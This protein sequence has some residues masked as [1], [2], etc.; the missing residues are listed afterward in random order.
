MESL[1]P[2]AP[3]SAHRA[4]VP[5][6]ELEIADLVAFGRRRDR[7]DRRPNGDRPVK[8]GRAPGHNSFQP[9][10]VHEVRSRMRRPKASGR[11]HLESCIK[12][13]DLVVVFQ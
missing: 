7:G 2:S 12:E 8:L 6:G 9:R 13:R 10:R 11:L 1:V 5:R 3:I 4:A